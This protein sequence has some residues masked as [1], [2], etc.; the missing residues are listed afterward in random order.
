MLLANIAEDFDNL[1]KINM[2]LNLKKC[3]F[4]VEEGKFLGYMEK[5]TLYA[6]LVVSAEALSAVLLTDRKGRQC[7]VQYIS[8]TLNEAE[9]DYAPME[10]LAFSLIHMTRRLR[11]YFEAHPV[12]VITDQLIKNIL[13]NTETSKKLAK[14]VI[15]LEVYNITFI[16]RNAVKGQVLADFLSEA[17]EGE[18]KELYF[19]M[20]EVPLEKYDTKSWTLFADGASSLKGLGAGLV[21]I[22]P[23][24]IEHA[25]ALRL[26]FPSTNNEAEYEALLAGL[27]IAHQMNIS[28]IEVKVDSKPVASQINGSYEA[29]KDSM[30][31]YLPKAKEY[32]SGFKSFSIKNIPRN[33]NQK[34]D[35]LSKLASVAFNHLTKEVL[36]EVFNERSTEDQEAKIGQLPWNP[37]YSSKGGSELTSLQTSLLDR[38]DFASWK[39]RIQLYCRGKENGVNILKSIDEGPFQMGTLRET[40]TEGTEGALHLGPERPRVY[41]DLTSEEKDR[42]QLNSKFI[43]NMLPEWG[44]FITTMKLNR[45]LRNS[46]YDQL[47]A[48]LK[49]HEIKGQGNNARGAGAGG[50]EGAQNRV[51]YANPGQARQIKCYNCND[52]VKKVWK[53][54]HV[55]QVWEVTGTVLTTVG[56]QWKPTG[57]IFI[58]GE[59]CPLTRSKPMSNTKKIRISSAKSVNKKT[60]E[61]HSRT[62]KSYLQKLNRADS[63]I[64]SKRTGIQKALTTKIK[65]MKTIFDELEA[66]VD[67]N[68][69]NSKCDEIEPKNL[70]IANDTLTTNCLSKEVFYIAPN[71]E[72]NVSRFFEMHEAH[73]VVQAH[74]LELET[75]LSKLKDKIQKDDH[76][77]MVKRFSNLEVQYLNLHLKYQHLK[78]NLGN[79]NSLPAQDGPD[80]DSVF[81]I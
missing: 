68:G 6:Y 2:K 65:E 26:T 76:E 23:N 42:M 16:P 60:V 54:K 14:Y 53:P 48:Y 74:C 46:N 8:R 5:E 69:M 1:K 43:N 63:S 32:T 3:S 35:V 11:R 28:H 25:Y 33:I 80:F 18:K 49:Q 24:G 67:Q 59:Q 10:K 21:L 13:N 41:S 39:Q 34:A 64:S 17:P 61:D 9:R 36:V 37:E 55:N 75:K 38:T 27:R 72:L 70:L 77:V 22:G 40:L 20:L 71:S 19:Q 62:N 66:E 30:I 4:R 15:E 73:I 79:N 57:R 29:S 45:G 12:K 47:Y 56:Y 44:R 31:K 52:I 51:E 50:Y 7:L 78:E 58:L 81:E